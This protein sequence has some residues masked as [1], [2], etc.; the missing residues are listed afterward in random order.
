MSLEQDLRAA[1]RTWV[2]ELSPHTRR[3]YERALVQFAEY[4]VETEVLQVARPSAGPDRRAPVRRDAVDERGELVGRAGEHLLSLGQGGANALVQA[5]VQRLS[6][7]DEST[8]VPPFTRETVKQRLSALR[9]AVREARRRGLVTWG[10][11][12]VLPR[13][14]KDPKTGRIRAKPGRNMRGPPL[15]V[16]RRMVQEAQARADRPDG[17]GG[18]WLLVLSLIAHETLREGEICSIDLVDVDLERATLSVVRK[19]DV[20]PTVLPLS[21]PTSAALRRWLAHRGD[22]P[23]PLLWG[24]R[25]ASMVPGTRLTPGG[26]YHV[27]RTLGERCGV[28][29]SPHKVRHTAITLGQRVREHLAI[30]LQDAMKRAGHRRPDTHHRY[31]DPELEGVRRLNDGVARLLREEVPTSEPPEPGE[32]DG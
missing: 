20:E 27:V 11:D 3:A 8:G 30:P 32:V 22:D 23:G 6:A 28:A 19:T 18:R 29:T 14:S 5:Y 17:D 1:V 24:S 4:L 7:V 31:L 9:W 10:L 26:V 12:V 16:L 13:A 25:R 21:E 2:D 15:D